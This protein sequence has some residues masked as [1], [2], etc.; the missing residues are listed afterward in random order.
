MITETQPTEQ[1]NSI[2]DESLW[3]RFEQDSLDGI[4]A[5]KGRP[6]GPQRTHHPEL[7]L[8]C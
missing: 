8:E 2:K 4:V 7:S 6:V 5:K 3:S 1:D